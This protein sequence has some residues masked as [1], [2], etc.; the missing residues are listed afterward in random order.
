MSE[1]TMGKEKVAMNLAR[2]KKGSHTFEIAIDSDLAIAFKHGDNVTLHEVLKAEH[3][4]SDAKKGDLASEHQLN[5]VFE[6]ADPLKVA[7]IILKDGDIQLT[8]EYRQKLKDEKEKQVLDL[9]HRNGVDPRNH[10]PHPLNR[11]QN[12]L[13]EANIHIDA[14]RPASEQV[15]EIVKKLQ[16]I[17]PISFEVKEIE[18]TIPSTHA[19]KCYATVKQSTT[20][21]KEEWLNDGGW[22]VVVRIPAGLEQDFYDK[23]NGITHGD[24]ESKVLSTQKS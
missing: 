5:E 16:P 21:L 24:N 22:R 23:V 18:L 9:I 17:L 11:I 12:A 3:I 6:T 2:L 13:A 20:I 8:A 1:N 10:T 7:E 4:F 15:P 19:P 14:F